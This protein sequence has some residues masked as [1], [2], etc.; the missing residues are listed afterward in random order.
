MSEE[1]LDRRTF[2]K[3]AAAIGTT[4]AAASTV[5]A[6]TAKKPSSGLPGERIIGRPGSDFMV[7]VIKATGI[8]YI[9]SN[10]A[11]S[12][13]SLH[14]S[15]V[16][17]GGNRKPE[18]LTCMHEESSV[19]MA[20]GYFKVTGKPQMIL[21][22]GSVGLQHAAMAVYNAWCDRAAVLLMGGTDLD[23]AKRPP[24]VP[25]THSAQDI[26][27]LV[28]DFTKWDDQP[29]S[30][31]HFAQSLVRAYKYMMTPP[32]EP[33]MIALDGG[34]QEEFMH[35]HGSPLYIPRYTPP[36]PPQAEV[37][38]LREAAKLLVNAENLQCPVID[39]GGRMNFPNTHHLHQ[40]GN[41][42]QLIR[43]ADVIMGLEMTDFWNT[44][45]Q[46]IDNGAEDGLG[47][48]EGRIKPGTKLIT[49]SG[50][51]LNQKANYQDFQRFQA[52]DISMAGDAEA[53][54]P[55]LIEAVKHEIS[56]DKKAAY[57]KRGEAMKK[58]WQQSRERMRAAAAVGWDLSPISTARL[59]AELY[60]A[61]KDLDWSLVN[62]GNGTS[63]W[64]NRFFATS[65]HYHWLGGS[66]GAGQGYGMPAAIGAAHANKAL[67][68]FSVSIQSDG[69]LM[70]APG[71]LWTA[72]R[73]E[74]PLLTVMHNNKGY[75]QEVMHVQRLSNRRVRVANNGKDFGPIGTRIENPDVDYAQLAK[76]MGWYAEG[77]I[78]DPKDL[79]PALKRAV[80]VVKKGQPALLNTLTQPR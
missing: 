64:P 67:G 79:A 34:L 80:E 17:Y 3:T 37:A 39:Q 41:A 1:G 44:V 14:E 31:Q 66:G 32:H 21:C 76:S 15:I 28:R 68:R 11:S 71:C 8:E 69:D 20:H 51:E 42:Q 25:T 22:H 70:Y 61:V 60:N 72:S 73:H 49:I 55:S 26:N 62:A 54:L 59:S 40:N 74:I 75:H 19:A 33:V 52:V 43:N 2:L 38:A 77:P 9:A 30:L 5:S 63:G 50:V 53:S 27:A 24:G 12:F 16:N 7:D 13:R 65:R 78:S 58:A 10:P 35:D 29:V 48:R 47:T 57:E 56:N 6:E 23:A 45:N 46:H 18:F 4:M 36:S